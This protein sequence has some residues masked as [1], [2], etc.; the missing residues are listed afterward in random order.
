MS[1]LIYANAQHEVVISRFINLT[2]EFAIEV[3]T[4]GK[5]ENYLEIL[6][7]IYDYHN[8]YGDSVDR[9]NWYDWIMIL[10]I[11][12]SVMTNGFFAG[13]ENTRN[14]NKVNSY[15]ILLT[16]LLEETVDAIDKMEYKND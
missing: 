7:I 11:N 9:Q 14:K 15:R 10:P 16:K 3:S 6:Q 1:K 12:I 13:L 8:T 2:K 4:P 5:Y